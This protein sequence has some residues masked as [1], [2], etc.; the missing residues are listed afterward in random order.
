MMVLKI[1]DQ[2]V[3]EL[4]KLIKKGGVVVCPTDT[5]YGLI[6][7]AK[8]KKAVTRIYLIKKRTKNKPLPVFVRN[9][10]MAKTLV[11]I[12]KDQEGFLKKVWPGAVTVILKSKNRQGTIGIRI[13]N[14]KFVL[15]LVKRAGPLAETSANISGQP[16]TT[17]I[18]EVLRYFKGRKYQP[19]LVLN[20][21]DLKPANPSQIIDLTGLEPVILRK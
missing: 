18:R 6:C 12:D 9:I 1:K 4:A 3:D 14:H 7:D 21:G 16:S 10:A 15:N 13:P 20:A 2:K 17:K 8:N 11:K 5:V 19:D